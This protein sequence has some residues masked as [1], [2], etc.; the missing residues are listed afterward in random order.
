M[1]L[2][3]GSEIESEKENFEHED[4]RIITQALTKGKKRRAKKKSPNRTHD[5]INLHLFKSPSF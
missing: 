1:E 5:P 2:K 3:V 4:K